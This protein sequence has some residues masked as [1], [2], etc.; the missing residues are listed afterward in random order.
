MVNPKN[1]TKSFEFS[2]SVFGENPGMVLIGREHK[3]ELYSLEYVICYFLANGVST[4]F[5]SDR[6]SWFAIQNEV[7]K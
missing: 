3:P 2:F 4:H 1:F 6:D 7:Q 5:I